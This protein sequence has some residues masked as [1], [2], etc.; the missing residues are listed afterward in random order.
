M[1][2]RTIHISKPTKVSVNLGQL[3]LSQKDDLGNLKDISLPIDDL[4]AVILESR[5]ISITQ[6]AMAELLERNVS[7]ITCDARHL[8]TG[9][10]LNLTGNTI[11]TERFR[12][13]VSAS[14]PLKKKL[15]QQ[16]VKAKIHN[17]ATLLI[18][19]EPYKRYLDKVAKDVKSG[20]ITN[21][22]GVAAA[23]YWPRVFPTLP[24][25]NRDNGHRYTNSLLNYG[26]AIVRAMI[27]RSLVGTGLM[28][29]L[30]IHH[31]NKYNHFCLA[32]DLMEPYRPFVDQ[33]VREV[34]KNIVEWP[35]ELSKE[36]KV[37]LLMLPVMDVIMSGIKR[38]ML[39]ATT[40]TSSSL[41]KCFSG[42]ARQI[43]YP[44][45]PRY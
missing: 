36:H 26:Y 11:Q 6:P 13:Q 12:Y 7:L 25:F 33:L 4:W 24:G 19:D 29:A 2:K 8:P 35:D 39:I 40:E 23:Y 17:Q 44:T 10:L 15:W 37:R 34:I 28:P 1:I 20:D 42:E 18:E 31:R 14:Q 27:A 3:I 38:P 22:E 43:S 30:G 16:T 32:D 9:V 5:Q 41:Y 21:R 45:F